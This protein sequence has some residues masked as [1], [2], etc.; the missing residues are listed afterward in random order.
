M[1]LI[2]CILLFIAGFMAGVNMPVQPDYTPEL[3]KV[4]ASIVFA[5][6]FTVQLFERDRN[7]Q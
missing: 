4:F 3:W 1:R 2:F 5:I 7:E 6:M